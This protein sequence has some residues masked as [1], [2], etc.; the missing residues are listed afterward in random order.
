MT[1]KI[2]IVNHPETSITLERDELSYSQRKKLAQQ[3]IKLVDPSQK[4]NL[5]RL[6]QGIGTIRERSKSTTIG[7]DANILQG[8]QIKFGRA[9]NDKPHRL[10]NN[11]P[12]II[13]LYENLP[14]INV[15]HLPNFSLSTTSPTRP[16]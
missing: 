14:F 4:P 10:Q 5:N 16:L 3:F 7:V 1:S 15:R 12:P 2:E 6:I 11:T 8:N 13:V 9:K